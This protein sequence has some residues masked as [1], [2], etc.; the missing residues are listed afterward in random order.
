MGLDIFLGSINTLMDFFENQ[1]A[2]YFIANRVRKIIFYAVIFR[3]YFVYFVYKGLQTTV[4]G[5]DANRVWKSREVSE[6]IF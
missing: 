1:W 6:S 3:I 5:N 2:P 4:A